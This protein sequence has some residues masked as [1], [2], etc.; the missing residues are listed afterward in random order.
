MLNLRHSL[1]SRGLR[2]LL[3]QRF[4]VSIAF[5][6]VFFS[7]FAHASPSS[8]LG[9]V[10]FPTT[11]SPE[12][13][14]LFL[15]GVAALHSFWY[16]EALKSFQESTKVDP[17]FVM[18]YWGEAMTHNKPLWEKQDTKA[19]KEALTKI[20]DISKIRV[21]ELSYLEA[22]MHLYGEGDKK[23]RDKAYANA[24][25]KIYRQYPKD[26]EATCFYALS[27]L[28][29]S[30][31][32]DDKL[33]SKVKAGALA[34]EV[35]RENPEHPCSAHYTIHAFD[36]PDLAV[37]ALPA[38][39]RYAEIAPA[40]HHANHMP[41]HIFVQLGMWP[42]A[43]ASNKA[44]WKYSKEWVE[45]E[46]L[47]ISKRD[48]HSL[49][50]LHYV[51]LQQGKY[52]KADIIFQEKLKDIEKAVKS[53]EGLNAKVNRRTAKYLD[54]MVAA[55]VFEK[56]QWEFALSFIEPP[57][58]EPKDYNKAALIFTRGFSAA[59]LGSSD[60]DKYL[61][62][63]Q[64]IRTKGFKENYYERLDMLDVW[65][66]QIQA[67]K[68]ANK[69]NFEEAIEFAKK[70]ILSEKK[71]PDPSGPPQVLKPSYELLGEILLEAGNA[72]EAANQFAISNSRHTNR[73]RSLLGAAR[74]ASATGDKETAKD[75][76][77]KF[78]AIWAQ[79]DNSL[80]E[81]AEAKAF[82]N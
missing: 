69:K 31:H 63:L 11:G 51:T 65:I 8:K 71:L 10:D 76:Y 26:L 25:E 42:E 20:K 22:V 43:V 23:T 57:G 53:P 2:M 82:L 24:M 59:K 40:S 48:Y 45:R 64:A 37:L 77:A 46:E 44:G 47:P 36:H 80:L 34:M 58:W 14:K 32:E 41:A 19:A 56:E 1:I 38:A 55:S 33:R 21:R 30:R 35:F 74:A 78:L 68:H 73:A 60:A 15:R 81:L 7:F 4:V 3:F 5:F 6:F 66:S 72:K 17:N 18:G 16:D 79:A 62:N 39:R 28:G 13:Q 70:A 9:S 29:A 49:Q 52:E 12:A 54:R 50:W 27:L 67:V 61:A 75:W